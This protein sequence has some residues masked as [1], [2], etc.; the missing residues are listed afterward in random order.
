MDY[1]KNVP[2]PSWHL[3]GKRV[4]LRWRKG[5][6]LPRPGIWEFPLKCWNMVTE[7]GIWQPLKSS[8]LFNCG[9]LI[10][11]RIRS[12]S[13][14]RIQKTNN[15]KVKITLVL[16]SMSCLVA[17]VLRWQQKLNFLGHLI[18]IWGNDKTLHQPTSMHA[19]MKPLQ[20]EESWYI[21]HCWWGWSWSWLL[22]FVQRRL[23]GET[24]RNKNLWSNNSP[25]REHGQGISAICRCSFWGTLDCWRV[26]A[27]P[28]SP[29]MWVFFQLN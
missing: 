10:V 4:M 29:E 11:Q 13:M 22:L 7:Y 18:W 5:T 20:P 23:P 8:A 14:V 1:V 25:S 28:T 26:S 6:A 3:Q 9:T 2:V 15:Q 17:P 21:H 27:C 16:M 24:P 19:C 12:P